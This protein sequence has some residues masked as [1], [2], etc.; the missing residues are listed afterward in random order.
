[1]T[2][3]RHI[4]IMHKVF[5]AKRDRVHAQPSGQ[6]IHLRFIGEK[7]LRLA[8]RAHMAAGNFVGINNF[9]V[10]VDIGNIIGAR[11]FLGPD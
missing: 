2:D 6:Q 11:R 7:A 8:R 1:M 3:G 4:A 5:S 10:D 9:F